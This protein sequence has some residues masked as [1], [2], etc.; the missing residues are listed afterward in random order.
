MA[1]AMQEEEKVR[2]VSRRSI[3]TTA[4]LVRVAALLDAAPVARPAFSP[5]QLRLIE[6]LVDRLIPSDENGPGARECGVANYVDRSFAGFL[7]GEKAR[8]IEGLAAVD[9][10]ARGTH[11]TFFA[12]LAPGK[13]DAVLTAMENNE[14]AG[15]RPD[16]RTFFYRV[17]QLALEGMF[18]VPFYGGNQGF[19]GWDLIRYP[20][21]RLAVS[22]DEQKL[23]EPIK[24]L[25]ASAH[26]RRHG[27]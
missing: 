7:A 17:R 18:G 22:P 4:P 16:S 25:R 10:F 9:V 2:R 20:G 11:G 5:S 26:G 15:F 6:A 8:F 12:G 23:R 27:G 3:V 13:K 19:A 1:M 21:P 24:P 14:A